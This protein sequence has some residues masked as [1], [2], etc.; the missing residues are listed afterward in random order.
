MISR[1]EWEYNLYHDSFKVNNVFDTDWNTFSHD[2]E[3]VH[4]EILLSGEYSNARYSS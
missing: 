2:G 4:E 1:C 3:F